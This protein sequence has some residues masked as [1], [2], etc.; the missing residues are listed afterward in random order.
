METQKQA[1][2]TA[3]ELAAFAL[4]RLKPDKQAQLREHVVSCG[5]CTKFLQDNP[6][7]KLVARLRQLAASRL[8]QQ[9][10]PGI[11]EGGT[12]ASVPRAGAPLQPV[13]SK[14][15]P[16]SVQPPGKPVV[17]GDQ[18]KPLPVARPI[19]PRD[20]AVRD[21]P[22]AV[23]RHEDDIP[24]DLRQQDRYEI[25]RKIG[26]GGMG[27]VFEGFHKLM[28]RR[29]AIK[30][31]NASISGHP[32]ALK[33]F[34][35]E[36]EAAAKLSHANIAQ[37]YDADKFGAS[38]VLI[39]EFI[40]GASLDKVIDDGGS[41]SVSQACEY[42]QQAACGLQHAL[43]HGLAH[44]DIKPSNLMLT[45][46][47]TVK[48]LDFGL[49]KF[50]GADRESAGLTGMDR[51]MGTAQYMAPE[52]ALD[53]TNADIRADI[54]A[55]GCT[56]YCL[57]TGA[58]PWEG[59]VVSVLT[60]HQRDIAQ[61]LCER[62]SDVPKPLSDLVDRMLAKNPADRPQ[63]P[64][65]VAELLEPFATSQ[66][67]IA[68][69]VEVPVDPGPESGG[70]SI[71]VPA[72]VRPIKKPNRLRAAL[73]VLLQQWRSSTRPPWFWPVVGGG[74]AALLLLVVF[75]AL[76]IMKVRTPEGTIVIENV[77][78]DAEVLVDGNKVKLTR[79]GEMVTITAVGQG[80]HE[81][82]VE[83]N[84]VQVW[85]QTIDIA[86]AGE[87]VTA[88]FEEH[89]ADAT[90]EAP[91]A[92][93]PGPGEVI[94]GD[95]K[96][97]GN[98]LLQL[99]SAPRRPS[100]IVFGDPL[101]SNY[102]LR[103]QV[104]FADGDGDVKFFFHYAH[105]RKS[106]N[107]N[108]GNGSRL[109]SNHNKNWSGPERPDRFEPNRWYNVRI[110]VRSA[111]CKCFVDERLL[112][113][114][115]DD[116]F[117]SGRIGLGSRR[118]SARF[119]DIFVTDM[120]GKILWQ[121]LPGLPASGGKPDNAVPVDDGDL[122]PDD[123]PRIGAEALVPADPAARVA[124]V[125]GGEWKVGG[126]ELTQALNDRELYGM[127]FGDFGWQDLD[128]SVEAYTPEVAGP[129]VYIAFNA[130]PDAF[131][132]RY[133]RLG[134]KYRELHC[135]Y[136]L[137]DDRTV[138]QREEQLAPG[139]HRIEIKIRG[140]RCECFVDGASMFDAHDSPDFVGGSIGLATLQ[141]T[142]RFRKI[143]VKS[144]EGVN[145]LWN[146]LPTIPAELT[147][148]PGGAVDQQPA[149]ATGQ[150]PA[151]ASDWSQARFPDGE[152][153]GGIWEARGNE[154]V[155]SRHESSTILFGNPAWSRYNFEA[156]F[157]LPNPESVV[158]FYNH[159]SQ[160]N[161][162]LLNLGGDGN[163][164][165]DVNVMAAGE[166]I[167]P[168]K[169]TD[170]KIEPDRWYQVRIE[171]R[172][173]KCRCLLDGQELFAYSADRL[174]AGRVGFSTP[175]A[176]HFKDIR[177]TADDGQTVLW[178]GLPQLPGEDR[179]AMPIPADPVAR[180]ARVFAGQWAVEGSELQQQSDAKALA[181]LTMGDINWQ[182]V[183]ISLEVRTP[184][185]PQSEVFVAFNC[186]DSYKYRFLRFGIGYQDFCRQNAIK[187]HT[188]IR[189]FQESLDADWHK[190]DI[191]IR[192]S[193]C[194]C[195]VDGK[196]LISDENADFSGG[197]LGLGSFNTRGR[198]RNITIKS[199]G[200]SGLLWTGLPTISG[201]PV[202]LPGA[203][204]NATVPATT[205][206]PA[207]ND[208]FLPLFNG[209]DLTG[210]ETHAA[211]PG[212]WQV[213]DGLL[214]G[215]SGLSYLYSKRDDLQNVHVRVRA[216][217]SA[218]GNS[219]VFVRSTYGIK[220]G[221]NSPNGY[222]AAI[223]DGHGEVGTGG[224]YAMADG[225]QR[226]KSAGSSFKAG[227][228]FTLEVIAQGKKIEVKVNGWKTAEYTTEHAQRGGGCLALQCHNADTVIEFESIE[229]KPLDATS[230]PKQGSHPADAKPFGGRFYKFF[231]ES[232]NW[233]E[234]RNRCAALGGRL[235]IVKSAAENQFMTEL[236]RSQG[237]GRD[238]AWLGATDELREG[239]W[240]WTD[241]QEMHY[242]NWDVA[243]RQPNNKGQAEHYLILWLKNGGRWSDQPA[244]SKAHNPG[245]ICQ[246]E[247]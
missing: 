72:P 150:Q 7:E 182:D 70:I 14:S 234:A 175:N 109:K 11:G 214:V 107:F 143:I 6:P 207:A 204:A 74:A 157:K 25:V 12:L 54:Y 104:Q 221:S 2:P 134:V 92:P 177:V 129:A 148:L 161:F 19:S 242:T 119:R 138:F 247:K 133:L 228:F 94:D 3:G 111:D 218:G 43:E 145:Q 166:W 219:G 124:R 101:W 193:R 16:A 170:G 163:A 87:R 13:V 95:W 113:E 41:L 208:G 100:L 52:Q 67:T 24:A 5:Q 99:S 29:V 132:F 68:E 229:I 231:P 201:N 162:H 149:P 233:H 244:T 141:T 140:S 232:L 89:A 75:A 46:A 159:K 154:L 62:R 106:R 158:F 66:S 76:G 156:K 91:A 61:P 153:G 240:Q 36:V 235:A 136:G 202:S 1:H 225:A 97:E 63:S 60:S 131:K 146:G 238:A 135:V 15:P 117:L 168:R 31:I 183:D 44:R 200:G 90:V 174:T 42:V 96:V 59:D 164:W 128:L 198:F 20:R 246:W 230:G 114:K 115:R 88:Q 78:A 226:V 197:C 151:A 50:H 47:G 155:Q 64:L 222:E 176:A 184:D 69:P 39:S 191:K 180:V 190:V 53:A 130:A 26:E 187:D 209:K 35:R 27:S 110:E 71:V 108:F 239:V 21:A 80:T 37:A 186:K 34:L 77:P 139:W 236:V 55:L 82:R 194:E 58:P 185:A 126:E 137:D 17:S 56:L 127:S 121:G 223:E 181:A 243:G 48:I 81:L 23:P 38:H 120:Q 205:P 4:K 227:E 32:D 85:A 79:A 125:F 212:D 30:T 118:T 98:E 105:F 192:A 112:F 178:E 18:A 22:Q 241:G 217:F 196:P 49:A 220:P 165:H 215:R 73:Q 173:G 40:D 93:A 83:K 33:R 65:Q 189:R 224:L 147:P 245:F 144:G 216:R 169:V 210:W 103:C 171:M 160:G 211:Q 195:F 142:G 237:A 203:A 10:T 123:L 51:G 84:G 152:V 213:K 116:D 102:T 57:L 206:G 199:G 188:L 167:G 122:D 8:S 9:S 45:P 86:V 28:K 172:D 179:A